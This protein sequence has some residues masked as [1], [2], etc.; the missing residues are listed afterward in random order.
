MSNPIYYS[1]GRD[2]FDITPEQRCAEDEDD[3]I[4]KILSDTA[5]AKYQQY[6]C[7][8]LNTGEHPRGQAPKEK[9]PEKFQGTKHWRLALLAAKRRFISFDCDSFDS[10]KT[11]QALIAH[12]QKHYKGLLYTTFN[13]TEEAPRCRFV[14]MLDS[15]VDRNQG[16]LVCEAVAN[17]IDNTLLSLAE[18][19]G[20]D[21]W[22]PI[23]GWDKAVYLA[24][25]QCYLPIANPLNKEIKPGVPVTDAVTYKFDGELVN[26]S[27]CLECADTL[28][29]KATKN[30]SRTLMILPILII[31]LMLMNIP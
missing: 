5:R 22:N 15:E 16:K 17:E 30:M 26:V 21:T 14:L 24:E 19:L 23:I 4:N 8:P 3:F 31:G 25:Q 13:Y 20:D 12:L 27:E 2:K 7:A 18:Q 29:L 1:R 10:P 11:Y 6:F 9:Y 28:E